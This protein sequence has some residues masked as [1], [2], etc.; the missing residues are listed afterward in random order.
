MS[1]AA[2]SPV[3]APGPPPG[4]TVATGRDRH[5]AGDVLRAI[6]VFAGAALDV[7]VLGEYDE[8]AGVRRG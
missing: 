4:A 7:V 1:A 2:I 8:E 6:A 3:P 5:R